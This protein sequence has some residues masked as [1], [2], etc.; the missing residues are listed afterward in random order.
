LAVLVLPLLLATSGVLAADERDPDWWIGLP[1]AS[2]QVVAWEGGV[3]EE[4]LDPLLRVRQGEP[5]S[6]GDVRLDLATLFHAGAFSAAEADVEPWF[7]Y[8]P[9]GELRDAVNVRY[10]V[11]AAPRIG[12]VRVQGADELSSR[13][14]LD[15][16]ALGVGDTF[17]LDVDGPR[18]QARVV[19]LYRSR[20]FPEAKVELD[21]WEY[22]HRGAKRL[23]VWVRVAEG[24][25]RRIRKVV[26]SGELPV[27]ERRLRRLA[28]RHG[29]AEGEPFAPEDL[30]DA[31]YA[32]RTDLAGPDRWMGLKKGGW[33]EA[34]VTPA[35]TGTAEEGLQVAFHVE[36]GA[37]L[38][39]DVDGIWPWPRWKV[40]AALGIDERVRLTRGFLEDAPERLETSM[41]RRGFLLATATVS[42]EEGEDRQTL[43]VDV[44]RGPRH[45]LAAFRPLSPADPLRITFEGN[46]AIPSPVLRG[47]MM[48]ASEEVLRYGW[49]T[50]PE[51]EAGIAAARDRYRAAGYQDARLELV[52]VVESG[53]LSPWRIPGLRQIGAYFGIE[54]P[55]NVE[56]IV[57]VEEN[58]LTRLED[59]IVQGAAPDVDLAFVDDEKD[60]LEDA[61]YSPSALD[62]L[63]RRIVA[64]HRDSGYLEADARVVS[65]R[66][67]DGTVSST[68]TVH[69]GPQVLLRSF[70]LAGVRAT[71]PEFLRRQI[72]PTLGEPL[73]LEELEG[74]RRSLYDLGV[75]RTV[76]TELLGDG[77]A[78]DLV[79]TVEERSRWAFELGGGL[80]T[81]QGVR[82]YGR[83]T[84]N[85]VW[86]LAHRW[87]L[88][89]LVGLEYRS[90]SLSDWWFDVRNPEWR[91]A[92]TYTAPRFPW[93]GQTLVFD[94]LLREIVQERAWRMTRSG[95]GV[96]LETR[97]GRTTFR[98]GT[99][100]E[101]RRLLEVDKGVI[102]PNEPWAALIGTD[103]FPLPSAWREQHVASALLLHD[104]RDD[105]LQPTKGVLFSG[106]AEWSP[107]LEVGIGDGV[108]P[109]S[110]FVRGTLRSSAYVP[111]GPLV[112]HI[113][114]EGARAVRLG[115]GAL[116]LE[117][118]YRLGG[119][120]NLRGFKR[121]GVGPRN[122]V[123]QVDIKWP[124]ALDPIVEQTVRDD[125]T[126]W[127]STG[128]DARAVGTFELLTPFPVLGLRSYDG[129]AAAVFVD[130]GNVWLIDATATSDF[131]QYED[132]FQPV[133]R[134]GVG[135]G[136]RVGTP[137]GPL[138]VD[139][140]TNPESA[141]AT[142]ERRVLLQDE[143]G[144]PAFRAHIS[145]GTL[146]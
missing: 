82:G 107:G 67:A 56:L 112:A 95:M 99:R 60:S 75:F 96:A 87:E 125:P 140:A 97:V 11:A 141:L 13:D 110:P 8:G 46:E 58:G 30:E 116:P 16:A 143:W 43:H 91:A 123:S 31:Q 17:H 146:F 130:V 38:A 104:L 88:F 105:P 103:G 145:L 59:L 10:V 50:Y 27:P 142:G 138:Q 25:A 85:N 34:R 83:I 2:V 3:P 53:R 45:H 100:S 73:T 18:V 42:L 79:V 57:H 12:R 128:G 20:G 49:F 89:G 109:T 81:D 131:P 61:P 78:R 41:Q 23:E 19:E 136:L 126:R 127:V 24:P 113:S 36:P 90:D 71:Q 115:D 74:M 69:A 111:V 98:A 33:I 132:I 9:D 26:L 51:V 134:Y 66:N 54:P 72:Q 118:R 52:E 121:D 47:V 92:A 76:Q 86:G 32:L 37:R 29:V 39:I 48:Q 139:L 84:R 44:T 63:A 137:V 114:A 133:L 108:V 28:A 21:G 40:R 106:L 119:T 70:V 22:E 122:E 35:V 68:I 80:S 77:S 6:P 101:T 94:V 1:V 117:E 135:A 14:V 102:L 120:G 4:S 7:D 129:Y 62:H 93:K 55:I 124:D 5:L 64:A 65:V 15:A 144:E